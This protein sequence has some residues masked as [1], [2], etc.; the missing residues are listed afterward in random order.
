MGEFKVGYLVLGVRRPAVWTEFCRSV[1]G[2]Q[3]AAPDDRAVQGW[4]M[5]EAA[6]RLVIAPGD[7]DLLA[8]G[9]EFET[10][11]ALGRRVSQLR[12]SGVEVREAS[13][14]LVASRRV[15]RLYCTTD[16]G[17]NALE[18]F[19]GLAS[20]SEPF[21]SQ[22]FPAGFVTGELGIGHAVLTVAN[23]E[24]VV[25]FYTRQLG[26]AITERLQARVGPVSFKGV[27]LHCN[28]RHHSLALFD[29]PNRK[30]LQHFMLEVP[31]AAQ[32]ARAFDRAK[33]QRV[34][35]TLTL[36]QHPDPD[37]TFSFY[38]CTPSGFD[39]EIGSGGKPIE[40][41]NWDVRRNTV[42]SSWGHRPVFGAKVR[43]LRELAM[44]KLAR[45]RHPAPE[46]QC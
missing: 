1:L 29:L 20:G 5:D 37:G 14:E 43:L 35:L 32:V 25:D 2:L 34:P 22:L 39:F 9:L 28:R 18:L 19:A 46:R 16:P 44:S 30:R 15:Q 10:E 7:D 3:Q 13:P 27:F 11:H 24:R 17:G 26:F 36:G 12:S 23:L 40:P 31:E 21:D 45:A 8:I 33:S 6:Y 4:R 42:T 41:T 38:G